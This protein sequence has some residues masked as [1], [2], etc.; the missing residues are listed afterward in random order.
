MAEILEVELEDYLFNELETGGYVENGDLFISGKPM[1]QV[2]LPGYGVVDLLVCD[3]DSDPSG[4]MVEITIVELKKDNI[5]YAA[6]GQIARYNA[7]INRSIDAYGV[8]KLLSRVKLKVSMVLIGNEIDSNDVCWILDL[9]KDISVYTYDIDLST[10]I[11]FTEQ[12]GWYRTA[13]D[14]ESIRD[15]LSIAY[16]EGVQKLKKWIRYT[17]GL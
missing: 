16:Q 6:L 3:A 17:R 7:A 10:G 1:R 9:N 15:T 4:H 12:S 11:T 13:E 8:P 2:A 5:N 14:L